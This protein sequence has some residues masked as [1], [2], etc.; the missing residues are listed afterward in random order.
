MHK[1]S[2]LLPF[3]ATIYFGVDCGLG[4]GSLIN[5][6]IVGVVVDATKTPAPTTPGQKER[7]AT[8]AKR[9]LEFDDSDPTLKRPGK[10][11]LTN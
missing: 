3:V 4:F 8:G 6:V 9:L 5:L 10:R 7:T 2:P 1:Y 11:S